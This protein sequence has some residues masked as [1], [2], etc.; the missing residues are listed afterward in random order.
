[1]LKAASSF[2]CRTPHWQKALR[3][4]G[5]PEGSWS[6]VLG[7]WVA[8]QMAILQLASAWGDTDYFVAWAPDVHSKFRPA[9]VLQASLELLH[10]DWRSLADSLR[11]RIRSQ[12]KSEGGLFTSAWHRAEHQVWSPNSCQ[13]FHWEGG[14]RKGVGINTDL[15]K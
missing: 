2:M 5:R 1:M 8:K 10:Q 13:C 14:G 3:L 15:G 11:H 6:N 9:C 7:D 12:W 4:R